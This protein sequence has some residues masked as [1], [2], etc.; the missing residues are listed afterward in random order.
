MGTE[1][2]VY[3]RYISSTDSLWS[4]SD[5]FELAGQNNTSG[6]NQTSPFVFNDGINFLVAWEDSRN[7]VYTDIY[8]QD[9]ED[10]VAV[11]TNGGELLC[12]AD[13]DQLNPK[14]GKLSGNDG[15]FLIYWDDLRSSG[16]EFLNNVFAQ[17]YTPGTQDLSNDIFL[18]YSYKIE[19][20]YPNPFNPSISIEFSLDRSDIVKLSVYDIRGRII[21]TLIQDYLNVGSYTIDW[22]PSSEISSG[23]Y[24]VRLESV[25]NNL[26]VS[27]KN[28][29]C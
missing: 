7:N 20:A 10:G 2:D 24:I 12:D 5:E 8:F 15:S 4:L 17:S 1:Y 11:L 23:L 13:F 25:S 18:E 14:I 21:S 19:S 26:S 27:E 9:L 29:V 3:C 28:Y 6:G 22:S 16:K